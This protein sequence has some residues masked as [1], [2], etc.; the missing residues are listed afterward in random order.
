MLMIIFINVLGKR[1]CRN[2]KVNKINF[3]FRQYDSISEKLMVKLI[4]I[5]KEFSKVIG[6]VIKL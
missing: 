5:I 3:I 1:K 4:K 6:I 2:W